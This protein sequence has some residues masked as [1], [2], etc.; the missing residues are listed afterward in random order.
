MRSHLL[1][2]AALLPVALADYQYNMN[3]GADAEKIEQVSSFVTR[4][5][6]YF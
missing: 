1:G 5:D 3:W 4:L 6:D 2:I